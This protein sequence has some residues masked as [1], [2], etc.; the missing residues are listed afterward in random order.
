[1]AIGT[2]NGQQSFDTA[3]LQSMKDCGMNL[4][5]NMLAENKINESLENA[6]NVGIKLMVRYAS[7][8][9]L[10]IYDKD[11]NLIDEN[12]DK[13]EPSNS[14]WDASVDAY[15]DIVSTYNNHYAVGGWMISDEPT[16]VDFWGNGKIKM[17]IDRIGGGVHPVFA[18]LLPD[19][20]Y[21][22]E[23]EEIKN[24]KGQVVDRVFKAIFWNSAYIN[25]LAGGMNLLPK[26]WFGNY[27]PQIKSYTDYLN[28]FVQL[29]KPSLL[30]FDSYIFPGADYYS[31][32]C[33]LR[34]YRTLTE[35][36]KRRN[37]VP[38]W[39]TVRSSNIR[40]G[41]KSFTKGQLRYECFIP[42]MFGA[43]GL[44]FWRFT[45]DSGTNDAPLTTNG[46]K[47]E[48]FYLLKSVIDQI[49]KHEYVFVGSEVVEAAVSQY[50]SICDAEFT[51][52]L[53]K[54]EFKSD[55]PVSL[56]EPFGFLTSLYTSGI[57]VAVSRIKKGETEYLVVANLDA[58][59]AQQIKLAFSEY[60]KNCMNDSF[61]VQSVVDEDS[62][63]VDPQG[64]IITPGDPIIGKVK[65]Y[66]GPLDAGDWIIFEL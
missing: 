13:I 24:D 57:G 2:T 62:Q 6:K 9:K 17:M 44:S 33:F 65:N 60:V 1:M 35:F 53:K 37:E 38:F 7:A 20:T 34:F 64:S 10:S 5:E 18:N 41:Y 23:L 4:A 15:S 25:T 46:E 49:K 29:S 11:G 61:P 66:I 16:E 51:P 58:D 22:V 43:C 63:L 52:N 45:D 47:T 28:L 30:S 31:Y 19:W 54:L 14:F 12:V 40:N 8:N 32:S 42:L 26:S 36:Y 55:N 3:T 56:T 27:N 21:E 39:A 48:T 59:N 50:P